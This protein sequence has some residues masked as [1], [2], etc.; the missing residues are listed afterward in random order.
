[1]K[2]LLTCCALT[3]AIPMAADGAVTVPSIYPD[4]LSGEDEDGSVALF[5]WDFTI[6]TG[7]GDFAYIPTGQHVSTGI[8]Q[9]G[10]AWSISGVPL[11]RL[12]V[13]SFLYID[14]GLEM[15]DGLMYVGENQSVTGVFTLVVRTT[16]SGVVAATF[17]DFT[18]WD[19]ERLVP[20]TGRHL[21]SLVTVS[22]GSQTDAVYLSQIPEPSVI[23]MG[24]FALAGA[25]VRRRRVKS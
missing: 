2:T 7:T 3:C 6:N 8:P 25:A 13:S 9:E 4:V 10:F 22:V 18:Y 1:M 20:G 15:E 21:G 19:G 23:L 17:D 12:L 16:L 11:D 14:S 5:F 24:G